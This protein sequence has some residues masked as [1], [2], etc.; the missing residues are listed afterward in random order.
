MRL[1]VLVGDGPEAIAQHDAEAARTLAERR[2]GARPDVPEPGRVVAMQRSPGTL[3]HLASGR[4]AT[5][6]LAIAAAILRGTR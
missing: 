2:A 4:D 5:E 3:E 6:T 1:G